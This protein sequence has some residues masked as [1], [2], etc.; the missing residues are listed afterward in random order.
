MI[1]YYSSLNDFGT[2]GSKNISIQYVDAPSATLVNKSDTEPNK[3][4]ILFPP[5]ILFCP[6]YI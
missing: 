3:K 2:S 4:S 5:Y 6:K 1:F